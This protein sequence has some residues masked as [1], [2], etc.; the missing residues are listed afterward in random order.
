MALCVILGEEV[1]RGV[2]AV[3]DLAT[4][5]QEELPLGEAAQRIAAMILGEPR[6]SR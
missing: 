2:V 3:R 1:A 5:T 6:G 4:R